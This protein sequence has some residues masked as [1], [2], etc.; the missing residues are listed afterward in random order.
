MSTSNWKWK[1]TH[2]HLYTPVQIVST[3]S[4]LRCIVIFLRNKCIFTRMFFSFNRYNRIS[5]TGLVWV[6][7]VLKGNFALNILFVTIKWSFGAIQII[8]DTFLAYFCPP[9]QCVIFQPN[10]LVLHVI[11]CNFHILVFQKCGQRIFKADWW[12]KFLATPVLGSIPII[13]DT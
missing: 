10:Q 6:V 11:K 8:R 9:F 5:F 12:P 1:Q 3:F 4:I 13:R 7:C 2:T